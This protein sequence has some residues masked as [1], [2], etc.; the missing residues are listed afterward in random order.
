MLKNGSGHSHIRGKSI[1]AIPVNH[2]LREEH[3]DRITELKGEE[4]IWKTM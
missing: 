1:K 2:L 4:V 3:F